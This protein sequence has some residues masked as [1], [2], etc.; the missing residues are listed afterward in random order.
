VEHE[1]SSQQSQTKLPERLAFGF[2]FFGQGLIYTLVAQF[3]LFYYTDYAFL[4]PLVISAVMFG[5]KIWDGINDPLFGIIVDKVRFKS[6][7]RFLPWLKIS[8]IAIPLTTILLFSIESVPSIGWRIALAILTYA[9]W[10]LAYTMSDAPILGL[11]TT[12]SSNIKERG[13]LM[14]FAGAGGAFAMALSAIFLVPVFDKA[15]F[16]KASIAIAAIALIT[17]GFVLIFGRERYYAKEAEQQDSGLSETWHYLIHNRYLLIFFTYRIISGSIAVSMITYMAKHCLGDVNYVSKVALFALPMIVL[18]YI[19]APF[20]M[21]RFDKI[22][23]YRASALLS[24][25]M[26]LVTFLIGYENSTLVVF[27]M[28]VIAALA[29]IP[30]ILMG[31]IPQDCVEYGTFKTGI[32]KEGITFALQS[33]VA[34]LTA[35]FAAGLTGIFLHLIGYQG[36]LEVQSAATIHNIWRVTFLVPMLGQLLAIGFLFAYNLRDRDVQL[37]SD[38]NG[39]KISKDEALGLMSREYK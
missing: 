29:I 23:L 37:M 3:L 1:I 11:S 13:T 35:A 21:K 24:L 33:F 14:T 10:D 8:T 31:V 4:P 36:E 38:A 12:M 20:L 19:A 9:L 15:G 26:Y 22:I 25:G 28:S 2:Y 18:A 5:G 30:A 34:K 27:S 7:K 32:R 17:M 6:G 16:F 39:G